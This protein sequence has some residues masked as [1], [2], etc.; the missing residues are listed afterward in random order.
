MAEN[1]KDN[2]VLHESV[3]KPLKEL[4]D[5]NA[6]IKKKKQEVKKA[7][8][9]AKHPGLKVAKEELDT[10]MAEDAT[11]KFNESL[12]EEPKRPVKDPVRDEVKVPVRKMKSA[13]KEP[14]V[15][16]EPEPVKIAE[17]IKPAVPIPAAPKA[18]VL[19]PGG[20]FW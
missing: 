3:Q 4:E 12:L 8:F 19:A 5:L 17:T 13:V 7:M 10:K 14:E 2:F 16:P 1:T 20:V 15:E 18:F 9:F 6:Q 11:T